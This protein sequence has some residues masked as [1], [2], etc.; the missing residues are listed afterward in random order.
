MRSNVLK[1]TPGKILS[2][3]ALTKALGSIFVSSKSFVQELLIK[4]PT[5]KSV[6]YNF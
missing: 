6:L 1:T 3:V 2:G 5:I 4:I